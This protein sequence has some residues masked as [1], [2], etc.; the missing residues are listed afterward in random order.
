MKLD[1]LWTE[2]TR[3]A[4]VE[5]QNWLIDDLFD[6]DM[7]VSFDLEADELPIERFKVNHSQ[8]VV[9]K[10]EWENLGGHSFTGIFAENTT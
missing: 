4:T 8:G 5:P 10:M 6:R 1:D 7:E 2:V 3:D 9:A